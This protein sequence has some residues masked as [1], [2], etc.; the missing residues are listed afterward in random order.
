M[1]VI[2]FTPSQREC[3]E[4]AGNPFFAV[5]PFVISAVAA[6]IYWASDKFGIEGRLLPASAVCL[7]F[8]VP[9]C[10]WIA[11]QWI[12]D[13]KPPALDLAPLTSP[14]TERLA[15]TSRKKDGLIPWSR[16]TRYSTS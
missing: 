7:V 9:V 4:R 3:S 13:G 6:A 10:L 1:A 2:P 16:S 14:S 8:S 15:F 11:F 5:M 12:R